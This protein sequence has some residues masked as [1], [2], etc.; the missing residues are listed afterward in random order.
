MFMRRMTGRSVKPTC[1]ILFLLHVAHY[2]GT[3]GL[4]ERGVT[5]TAPRH[6]FKSNVH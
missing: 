5:G 3:S 6:D 2:D 1:R 4:L